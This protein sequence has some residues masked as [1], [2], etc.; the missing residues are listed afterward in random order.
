MEVPDLLIIN[1]E[2]AN[3]AHYFKKKLTAINL[4]TFILENIELDHSIC[5]KTLVKRL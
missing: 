1:S 3:L 2:F 4:Y 5:L